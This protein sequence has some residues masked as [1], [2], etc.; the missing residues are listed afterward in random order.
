MWSELKEVP[1]S[2]PIVGIRAG[3][4]VILPK[5]IIPSLVHRASWSYQSI[6]PVGGEGI[7]VPNIETYRTD[8]FGREITVPYVPPPLHPKY[9]AP[10]WQKAIVIAPAIPDRADKDQQLGRIKVRFLWDQSQTQR[11]VDRPEY[12]CWI[13]LVMPYAGPNHGFYSMPEVGDEVIVSF[14]SGDMDRPLCLG[15]VYNVESHFLSQ[16][17]T[18]MQPNN[19]IAQM[20]TARLKTPKNLS[21]EF[22]EAEEEKK[23]RI[24]LAA[25]RKI[26]LNMVIDGKTI[27]Y[28]L[29]S[30][31]TISVHSV[32]EMTEDS[33]TQVLIKRGDAGSIKIDKE[34][35]IEIKGKTLKI[36]TTDNT[37]V[38]AALIKL[39]C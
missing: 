34:G 29:D 16:S 6:E 25:D 28:I 19:H 2:K 11:L 30:K 31:G 3:D 5:L 36:E 39:N 23:Q 15:S 13:R 20:E 35:N 14:E 4:C 12:T 21:L 8:F 24:E 33:D 27:A 37:E 10:G 9:S 1:N 22:W 32:G 38:K 18:A 17:L 26:V 7:E